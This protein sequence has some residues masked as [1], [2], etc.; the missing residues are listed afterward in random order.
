MNTFAKWTLVLVAS[1][2]LA[3]GVLAQAPTPPKPETPKERQD[4]LL[5][6]ARLPRKAEDV[7][8]RGI[9]TEEMRKALNAAKSKGIRPGEMSDIA[10]EH[11]KALDEH[12]PIDNFGAFVQSQLDK[13]LRGRDLAAAIRAE[14]A[15]RGIGKGNVA[16]KG[17]RDRDAGEKGDKGKAD[18]PMGRPDKDADRPGKGDSGNHGRGSKGKG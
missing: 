6:A 7:R 13:G 10:D 11:R 3:N 12:G 15:K 16:D 18:K 1:G 9:P 14:H 4:R 8:A 2:S 17:R 5:K